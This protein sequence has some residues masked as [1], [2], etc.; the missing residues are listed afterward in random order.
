[1]D[2]IDGGIAVGCCVALFCCR[3]GSV[4]CCLDR[5]DDDLNLIWGDDDNPL[6]AG[7]ELTRVSAV[8][9]NLMLLL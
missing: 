4:C 3:G 6:T 2:K 5:P 9:A 8:E 1:V 7:A